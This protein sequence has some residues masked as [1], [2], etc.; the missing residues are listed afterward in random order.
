MN[1]EAK[2]QKIAQAKAATPPAKLSEGFPI[3]FCIFLEYC[4]SLTYDMIPDYKFLRGLFA[5]LF[6]RHKFKYDWKWDWMSYSLPVVTK[7]MNL[8]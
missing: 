6:Y 3:E 2:Y 7:G 5:N 4:R 1:K 8:Y